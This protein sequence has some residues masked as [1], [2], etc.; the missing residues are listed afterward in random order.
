VCGVMGILG[1]YSI[2]VSRDLL[3]LLTHRGQD[4]AGILWSEDNEY[5]SCKSMGSPAT[6]QMPDERSNLIIGSTRY[7]TS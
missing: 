5:E 2:L 7:P 4:A 3:R 6:I 1:D